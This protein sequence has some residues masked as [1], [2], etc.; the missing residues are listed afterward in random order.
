MGLDTMSSG[1]LSAFAIEARRRGKIDLEIDYN[2]PDQI[3]ALL[4]KIVLRQDVGGLL[5]DAGL[6]PHVLTVLGTDVEGTP[7]FP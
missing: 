3:A 5:A 1:N 2:Q 7:P 6:P 4:K